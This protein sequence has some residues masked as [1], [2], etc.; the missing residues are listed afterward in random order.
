LLEFGRY[1]AANRKQRGEGKPETFDF[2]GFTH[3][4][5]KFRSGR[6]LVRRQTMRTRLRRKLQQVKAELARRRHDPLPD[7]GQWVQ[8]VVV[9]HFNYYA[10]PG[11]HSCLEHFRAAVMRLWH[12][13]L[14]RRGQRR[15]LTWDRLGRVVRRWIPLVRIVHPYPEVRFAVRHPR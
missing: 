3:Y 5:G 13:A 7:Q 2:L 6:Y 1:A 15:P 8:R 10:V 9:G 12:R 4:C 14:R 11:N